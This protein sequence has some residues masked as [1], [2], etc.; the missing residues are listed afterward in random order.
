MAWAHELA[1]LLIKRLEKEV[2]EKGIAEITIASIM[3]E[4]GCGHNVARDTIAL[5]KEILKGKYS[6][7]YSRGKLTIIKNII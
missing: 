5:I 6:F 1:Q 3:N 4:F 7:E 2:E